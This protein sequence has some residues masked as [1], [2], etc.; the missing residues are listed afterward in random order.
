MFG[1]EEELK[2]FENVF[3]R[4]DAIRKRNG[5]TDGRTD[6]QILHDGIGRAMHSVA[7]QSQLIIATS[8]VR[9][10]RCSGNSANIA[11]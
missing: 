1:M 11:S 3:T 6:E 5:R 2:K 9:R 4:F 10:H 8:E 7:Q